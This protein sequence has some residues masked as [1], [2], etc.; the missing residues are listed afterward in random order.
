MS[1]ENI[2]HR[3]Q[4]TIDAY[5]EKALTAIQVEDALEAN[6]AALERVQLR[7]IHE[8]REL[9]S[10]LVV[11]SGFSGYER[12]FQI[13]KSIESVIED[14]RAAIAALPK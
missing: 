4:L 2:I 10:E 11:A 14:L 1:N 13:S 5:L 9:G 8:V 3:M 6:M 7:Q 12:E